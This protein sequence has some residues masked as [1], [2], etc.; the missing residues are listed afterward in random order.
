MTE[1][2]ELTLTAPPSEL[3]EGEVLSESDE[4]ALA[5]L[6]QTRPML[7]TDIAGAVIRQRTGTGR[8]TY[9]SRLN[10][11]A[12]A[13]G[14]EMSVDEELP[15]RERQALLRNR[16]KLVPWH[17]VRAWHLQHLKAA[18][19]DQKKS[20]NTI[21]L[22]LAAVKAVCQHTFLTEQ[23]T[24]DDLMRIKLV[25][26][27][28]GQRLPIGR[29]VTQGEI[30]AIVDA[31]ARDESAAGFRDNAILALLYACGL[32]RREVAELK[33]DALRSKDGFIQFLGKKNKE[34]KTFPTESV[35]KSINTWIK[36]RGDHDGRLFCPINKAGKISKFE[37]LTDQAIYN[38]V[39][40]RIKEAKLGRKTTPHDL[41]RSFATE[42]L[43]KGQDLKT[44]SNLMGH[45]SVETT[46]V[47]DLRDDEVRKKAQQEIHWPDP[48]TLAKE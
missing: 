13:W 1:S 25:S 38:V 35:W 42:L 9:E 11:A 48:S 30:H 46:S 27:V 37:G 19:I 2:R 17:V 23:M 10:Q 8:R 36:K 16:H 28:A 31:C 22:T 34:R 12:L 40:K 3:L 24:G 41:R 5:I 21:N 18:M 32:R 4:T 45:S 6:H 39:V 43:G 15:L 44:V 47:Y 20:Y 7:N 29:H 14:F 33:L 26:P